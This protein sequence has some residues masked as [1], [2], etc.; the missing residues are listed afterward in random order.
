[1][2]GASFGWFEINPDT[3][4]VV[5]TTTL[6]RELQEVFTLRGKASLGS[7]KQ[8]NTHTQAVGS[9]IYQ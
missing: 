3:G 6:D 7:A 1:M 4:E 5:T 9:F 8:T 2:P